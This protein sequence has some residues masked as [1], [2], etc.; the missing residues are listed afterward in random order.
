MFLNV[1]LQANWHG[2]KPTK[3]LI[4]FNLTISINIKNEDK[5]IKDIIMLGIDQKQKFIVLASLKTKKSEEKKKRKKS[6][7]YNPHLKYQNI[8][9][10]NATL[11]DNINDN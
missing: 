7:M 8:K 4:K 2:I 9:N 3:W 11:D 5:L 1:E 6:R 10:L